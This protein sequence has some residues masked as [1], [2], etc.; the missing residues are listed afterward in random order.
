[1]SDVLCRKI[2]VDSAQRISGTASNFKYSL[3]RNIT[4]P[5]KCAAFISDVAIPHTWTNVDEGRNKLYFR[6]HIGLNMVANHIV[7]IPN[8]NVTGS[9]LAQ[10]ID[11]QMNAVRTLAH[12]KYYVTYDSSRGRIKIELN[13]H[14]N[15]IEMQRKNDA[16]QQ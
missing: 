15:H 8:T 7:T 13:S 11:T 6:E 14:S 9:S 12:Y 3:V 2:Y 5:K 16:T 1:M 4:I 10:E